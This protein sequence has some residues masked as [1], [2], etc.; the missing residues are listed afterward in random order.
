[1]VYL[2]N[3]TGWG[4]VRRNPGG[5]VE[6]LETPE[7]D[8][9]VRSVLSLINSNGSNMFDAISQILT[10]MK[11]SN[12]HRIS[13]ELEING[14]QVNASALVSML[15]L[16]KLYSLPELR[17]LLELSFVRHALEVAVIEQQTK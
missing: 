1:M 5:K 6:G 17:R 10:G 13:Q 7:F 4:R 2:L 3:P 9:T 8:S 15:N 16:G 11:V 14:H 12:L